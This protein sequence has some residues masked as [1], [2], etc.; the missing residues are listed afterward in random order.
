MFTFNICSDLLDIRAIWG[1]FAKSS[2]Y[3]KIGTATNNRKHTRPG[4]QPTQEHNLQ[5]GEQEHAPEY[6]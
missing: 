1:D 3:Q 4:F 2:P 6:T 5:D